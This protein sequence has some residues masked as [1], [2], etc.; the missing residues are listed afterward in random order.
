MTSKEKIKY[1]KDKINELAEISS[2][3]PLHLRLYTLTEYEEGPILL[4]ASEQWS[5]IQKLEGEKFI[6]NVQLD[7]D[8]HGVW[9]E[10]VSH[11]ESKREHPIIREQTLEH[12]ARHLGDH[13]SGPQIVSWLKS[14]GVPDTIIEYPNTKW[15]MIYSAL[16]H[17]AYSTEQKDHEMLFKIISE[18]LHPLMFGGDK[19]AAEIVA[20]DFRKY[21]EYDGLAVVSDAKNEYSVCETKNLVGVDEDELLQEFHED[22]FI[23]E[24]EELANMRLP[25][26]KEKI[27]TLRKAY[28]VYMNI[29]EVF[30]NNPSRPSHEMNDA[31]IKTKK[32]VIGAV[33]D[34]HLSV[35]KVNGVPRI[36]RLTHYFIP[37]NNLFSAEKE[38]AQDDWR[39]D[40]ADRKE[41]SWNYIRPQMHATY[42]EIDDLYRKVEGS[43]ILSK[44]DV[45]QT[46]NDVSLLL[47][48]TKEENRKQTETK[49]KASIPQTPIQKIEITAMPELQ[50][51][52]TEDN[53]LTKGKKRIH[54]PKFKPTDWAKITIRFLN[55]R[56]VL[57]TTDKKELV[58][59]DYEAL[60]F[61]DEKRDKPNMAWMFF[62]GLAQNNGET[63]ALPNPIPDN[64]K[65]Q[66][67]QLSDCLKTI[68]KNDTPPFNDLTEHRTYQIKINLTPPQ[69]EGGSDNLGVQDYLKET[70]TEEYEK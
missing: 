1:V 66:K 65:Q 24:Q 44:P 25:E 54:L 61:A 16:S 57:I 14:W 35:S 28:Q 17:Y 67:R 2:T 4:S 50:V 39:T 37:F 52:N 62:Y 38:Y 47:S 5:I 64:I 19:E 70:M 18:M 63:K 40:P 32:M 27:S 15:R 45:Q 68:F 10:M 8:K 49:R 12:I 33:D 51:R 13:G 43:E 22:L 11:N 26:N 36:H 55:E 53:T 46:L 31:Y 41:L 23:Q 59:S 42:G 69:P 9:F 29:T 30:C 56:N 7:E 20:D 58:P 48:K 3:G 6:Q 34:L 60:G 21:L